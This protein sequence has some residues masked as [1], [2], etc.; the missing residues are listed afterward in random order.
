MI[1]LY[2]LCSGQLQTLGIQSIGYFYV[3]LNVTTTVQITLVVDL[4][5]KIAPITPCINYTINKLT[6]QVIL[7]RPL[8][9]HLPT[10]CS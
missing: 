2:R 3:I 5:L 7:G 8:T 10:K 4:A 6:N 1:C 9:F